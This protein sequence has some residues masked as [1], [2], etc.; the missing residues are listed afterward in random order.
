MWKAIKFYWI[1]A[2]IKKRAS[3]AG[4]ENEPRGEIIFD[5][6]SEVTRMSCITAAKIIIQFPSHRSR[7]YGY[8]LAPLNMRQ[9][10]GG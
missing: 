2:E 1:C 7:G 10:G 3:D 5:E 9:H 8:K 4:K 6:M